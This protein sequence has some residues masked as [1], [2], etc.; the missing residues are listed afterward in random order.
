MTPADVAA[1]RSTLSSPDPGPRD[2]LEVLRD[3]DGLG[4]D[5]GRRADEHRGCLWQRGEERGAV[6]AVD[7]ADVEVGTE[8]LDGGGREL[9][10]D[11]DDRLGHGGFLRGRRPSG[12]RVRRL[13]WA[14]APSLVR[15]AVAPSPHCAV[16]R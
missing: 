7:V 6:G 15:P 5:L 4:I 10:G 13:Q 12:Q 2:D 11:Q 9:F 8:G 16:R 3:G 14:Q 1:D